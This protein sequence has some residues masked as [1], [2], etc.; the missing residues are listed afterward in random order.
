MIWDFFRSSDEEPLTDRQKEDKK[1]FDILKYDGIKAQ[2]MRRTDYAIRCFTEALKIQQDIETMNFLA[3]AYVMSSAYEKALE[4]SNEL[5][6]IDPG[7]VSTLL[8]RA[9][10]LFVMD[11]FTEVI[12]DCTQIIEL[13][14]ANHTARYLQ[15]RAQQALGDLSGSVACL[16]EAIALAEDFAEAYQLRAEI[17]VT[18]QRIDEALQ[19]ADQA[20]QLLSEDETALL[21]RGRIHELLGNVAKAADDYQQALALNPFNETSYLTFGRLLLQQEKYDGAIAVFD[22]AIE[23]N[24]QSAKVYAER[25]RAKKAK[26]DKEGAASDLQ[27]AKELAAE[28]E[29]APNGGEQN[30]DDL[31][32]GNIL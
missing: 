26:G 6:V 28:D 15:A 4:V 17:Y 30:F 21:L 24:D 20:V 27:Q 22:E 1:N 25:A 8:T 19:D 10:L 23:H 9:N 32:K 7:K 13:D 12:A 14:P 16:S 2:Q 3:S 11:R 29:D 31:Y 18:M 5:N